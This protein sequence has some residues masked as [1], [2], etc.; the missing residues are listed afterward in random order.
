M[1]Q[2]HHQQ[3]PHHKWLCKNISQKHS[4]TSI[5]MHIFPGR[6]GNITLRCSNGFPNHGRITCS[7]PGSSVI[8]MWAANQPLEAVPSAP[9][10]YLLKIRLDHPNRQSHL[11]RWYLEP[12]GIY[13]YPLRKTYLGYTYLNIGLLMPAPSLLMDV[14]ALLEMGTTLVAPVRSMVSSRASRRV[15]PRRALSRSVA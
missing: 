11:L 5:T 1:H 4:I 6:T 9:C 10:K 12:Q 14:P 7:G 8:P 13:T 15:V 2:L 3:Q